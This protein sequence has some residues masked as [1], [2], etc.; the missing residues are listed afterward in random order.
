MTAINLVTGG[1][2]LIDDQDVELV[3]R[4][5]WWQS[6]N[7]E[8]RY[9][10]SDDGL[11][12]H[13]LI[14]GVTETAVHVDHVNH[15]GLD[16]RRVNLRLCNH[17]QNQ[18]NARRRRDNSSGFRG[19][20]WSR[21]SGKY[22]AQIRD[23]KVKTYLGSYATAEEAALAYDVAARRIFGEFANPNF[24]VSQRGTEEN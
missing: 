19:V 15:D 20:S 11:L 21:Q 10:E 22:K 5:R 9:A 4:H 1:E 3:S 7:P 24:P 12:M 6:S 23:N 16:N 14:L 17:T 13:R 2:A 8:Y 18:G